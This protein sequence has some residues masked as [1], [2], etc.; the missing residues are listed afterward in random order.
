VVAWQVGYAV[1]AFRFDNS[2]SRV[3]GRIELG[4]GFL[5]DLEIA[6]DGSFVILQQEHH[7]SLQPFGQ[8][9]DADGIPVGAEFETDRSGRSAFGASVATLD[10][11]EFVVVGARDGTYDV[12]AQR[13]DGRGQPVGRP[14]VVHTDQ[15]GRQYAPSAAGAGDGSMIVAWASSS[16][17]GEADGIFARRL[18]PGSGSAGDTDR[19]GIPDVLDNCPTVA[20]DQTDVAGDGYGDA[21]VS[22]DVIIPPTASIGRN[23]IIGSGTTLEP[24]VSIGDDASL[25]E[26]VQ[27]GRQVR[28]GNRLHVANDVF[29]GRRSTI[30]DD[31]SIGSATR[32]EGPVHV[33]NGVAIGAQVVL[34][35]NASI[36]DRA[37]IGPLV[38]MGIGS[39]VGRG[40]TLETGVR[41]GRAAV[42]RPGAVV[43]AGVTLAPGATF[44]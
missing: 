43:P 17:N 39:R 16:A 28:A 29:I 34:Q 27:I 19:D 26:N 21:C 32:L 41:L 23:P 1:H 14:L 3:G 11:G 18:A 7:P 42:V 20:N 36:A 8:R 2:G 25:G 6:R 37:T 13:F 4:G 38:V 35:R 22:P 33:G 10:S 12:I 30:G 9:Y 40:A 5:A 24:S 44:P 31:V 15:S